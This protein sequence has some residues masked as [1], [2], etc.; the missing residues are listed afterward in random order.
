[1]ALAVNSGLSDWQ[2]NS[3][4]PKYIKRDKLIRETTEQ[5]DEGSIDVEDFLN[6]MATDENCL[7]TYI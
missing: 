2:I 6:L 3:G 7:Y 4:N 1:M 5:L